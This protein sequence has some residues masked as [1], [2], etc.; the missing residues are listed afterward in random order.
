MMIYSE[1]GLKLTEQ[2]EGLRLKAYQDSVGKWTIGYGH[3]N[4]VHGGMVITQEQAEQFLKDDVKTACSEVSKQVRVPLTQGQ[5]DALVDFV[6]N[7]GGTRFAMSTLL[8]YL[9]NKQ[10]EAAMYELHKW[11]LVGGKVNEWQVKRRQ[12]EA[13]MWLQ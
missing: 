6:F 3:T 11:N 5:F 7:L 2:F 12:A 4:G 8:T 9:N 13:D 1:E 10:Y